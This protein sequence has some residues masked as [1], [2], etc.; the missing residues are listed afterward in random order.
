ME[1]WPLSGQVEKKGKGRKMKM[2]MG[3]EEEKE[4]SALEPEEGAFMPGLKAIRMQSNGL[5]RRSRTATA[6]NGNISAK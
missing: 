3:R 1:E 4:G 5:A 2:K 6:A